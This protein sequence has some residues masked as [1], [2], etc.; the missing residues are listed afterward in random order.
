MRSAKRQG[1]WRIFSLPWITAVTLLLSTVI[2]NNAFASATPSL[3]K[4]L[5][6]PVGQTSKLDFTIKKD[7][8]LAISIAGLSQTTASGFKGDCAVYS[9]AGKNTY[10]SVYFQND[11]VSSRVFNSD[12]DGTYFLNCTNSSTKEDAKINI[13]IVSF[14]SITNSNDGNITVPAMDSALV[15]LNVKKDIPLFITI[16]GAGKSTAKGF[17]GSCS[18]FDNSG[19][20]TYK[21][22][23]FRYETGYSTSFLPTYSGNII[24]FCLNDS[25]EKAVLDFGIYSTD[26]VRSGTSSKISIAPLDLTVFRFTAQKSQPLSISTKGDAKKTTSG[27]RGYCTLYDE[28]GRNSFSSLYFYD[29]QVSSTVITPSYSGF[30][31]F[32]CENRGTESAVFEVFGLSELK[33]VTKTAEFKVTGGSSTPTKAP[34]TPQPSGS[35]TPKPSPSPTL[36]PSTGQDDVSTATN[37]TIEAQGSIK[38][39]ETGNFSFADIQRALDAANKAVEIANKALK[40]A[41]SADSNSSKARTT[42]EDALDEAKKVQQLAKSLESA[43]KS[44]S[45]LKSAVSAITNTVNAMTIESACRD[46]RAK[47]SAGLSIAGNALGLIPVFG[48]KIGAGLGV[49]SSVNDWAA[50]EQ[51]K[52]K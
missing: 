47:I 39:I 21:S 9:N 20:D 8:P 22:V 3:K 29:N 11:Y 51:C 25:T 16:L 27:Y 1:L 18:I 52:G 6:I 34:T 37:L 33:Q 32:L 19:R 46:K 38:K 49:A 5:D 26:S 12:T 30:Y 35:S 23:P 15:N 42:A 48:D 24:L 36:N 2:A 50:I 28:D 13:T 31:Y 40:A 14:E 7:E 43:N 17:K 4:Q 44:I 41:T 10:T 45:N